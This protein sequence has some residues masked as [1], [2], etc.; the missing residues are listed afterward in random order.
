M[1]TEIKLKK[2][3]DLTPE[4]YQ[5]ALDKLEELKTLTLPINSARINEAVNKLFS[6]LREEQ[7]TILQRTK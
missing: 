6:M 4:D 7:L 1:G 5:L 3:E 2:P